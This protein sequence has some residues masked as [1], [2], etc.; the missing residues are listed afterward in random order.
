M[1][2][3]LNPHIGSDT[4]QPATGSSGFYRSIFCF[5]TKLVLTHCTHHTLLQLD[6]VSLKSHGAGDGTR[7]IKYFLIWRQIPRA[8]IPYLGPK[9]SLPKKYTVSLLLCEKLHGAQ[10]GV[11][12]FSLRESEG[13]LIWQKDCSGNESKLW[14][15]WEGQEEEGLHVHLQFLC[16]YFQG[17]SRD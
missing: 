1:Q 15:D 12:E 6:L 11:M 8:K 2:Y 17:K 5:E 16:F 3:S 9:M 4:M 13:V 10:H 7:C 14:S